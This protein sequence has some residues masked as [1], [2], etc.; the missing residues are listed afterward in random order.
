V[1]PRRVERDD[2]GFTL[3]ELLVVVVLEA[4]IV[5][6]L[7]SAFVLVMNSSTTVK[8]SLLRTNDARFTASYIVSD[9]RNS[10]G[11]ETS[12]SDTASCPDPSPPVSGSQTAVV[13]FNWNSTTSAGATTPNVV[14]YVQV[15]NS[16]L[17]RYCRNGA[18][19][20][21]DAL[22]TNIASASLACAP[23]ANCSGTPTA[24]TATIIETQG[25]SG[26]AAY[27][28]SVTGAFRKALA[29][30]AQLLSISGPASLPAWTVNRPYAATTVTGVGGGGTYIWSASGLPAGLTINSGTGV[31]S[32]TPTA[33]GAPTATVTLNDTLGDPAATRQ[34]TVTIN[35]APSITTASPLANGY[36]GVA[37][38]TTVAG[39]NGTTQYSWSATSLP[40][41]LAIDASTGVISGTPTAAGT[42]TVA[43][44]LTDAAGATATKNLSLTI[45]ATPTIT[46][47]VLANG[48]ATPGLMEKGDT[49]TATFSTQMS[50]SSLCSTWSGDASNQ[51]LT[52]SS[53]VTVTVADGTGATNDSI[54]VT[55]AT[56]TFHFGSINLGSN[57]YVISGGA[58]F[59][60]SGSNKSTVA[61][62]AATHT[63]VITLGTKAGAGT[64]ATVA[65]STPIYA[66]SGSIVDS[67]G[68]A[69]S[70]SPF[71]PAAAKQ[72]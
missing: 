50:V 27:Q 66:A 56:C 36:T 61:W 28:Y 32:G 58:T 46:G 49:I 70:N 10:S 15:S 21:D 9:A 25:S 57:A 34:Y 11:P 14:N 59:G 54:T 5:A 41:G 13:R 64:L 33:T 16:L 7:G 63:L 68:T 51:S 40:A 30:G 45:I 26:G 55:S 20:S 44:T 48:G 12:L 1:K 2:A 65:T 3:V 42:S 43:V 37:Y 18:L 71:T 31:V 22:A 67:V 23:T 72:F 35:A 24:I 4:M 60:G 8:D 47:V 69:L 39:S 38:S 29:V 52:G 19:V 17:R 53:D 6:A 62:T